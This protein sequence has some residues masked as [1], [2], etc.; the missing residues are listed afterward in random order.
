MAWVNSCPTFLIP[1]LLSPPIVA[2]T[3]IPH[4]PLLAVVSSSTIAIYECSSLLPLAL[5]K[6]DS[7]C[8]ATHKESVD[9]QI[10]HVSVDTSRLDQMHSVNVYVQTAGNYILIYHL[11]VNYSRSLYEVTDVQSDHLVQNSKPLAS[12]S[13]RFNFA[14]LIKSATKSLIQGG[15]ADTNLI[16]LEHFNNAALDDDQR[17]ENIPSVK[18]S[19]VKI[20]RMNAAITGFWC[21]LNS[22]N[23]IF[24]NDC[25][26]IQILNL[27]SFNN[28]IIKLLDAKWYHDT[29]LVAYN[30]NENYFLHLSSEGELAVLQFNQSSPTLSLDSTPLAKL[31]FTCRRILFNP[32]FNLVTLQTDTDLRIYKVTLGVK[33]ST[34]SYIKTLHEFQASDN[35]S[36]KWAPCGTFLI[37]W[38]LD[39]NYWKMISK[40]GFV[41]FDSQTLS[42]EIAAADIDAENLKA[43][44]DFCFVADCSIALNSQTLYLLNS[45]SSKIYYLDLLRL[46]ERF[47]NMSMFH[48]QTYVSV[49]VTETNSFARFPIL[50]TF[51]KVLEHFQYVNGIALDSSHRK[52]TGQLTIRASES[53]QLSMSYGP[54]LTVSTPIRIGTDFTHPLWYVFYNHFVEQL[55]IVDHFWVKDY[56]ILINRYARDDVDPDEMPDL[57]IDE[58]MIFNT[59]ASKHGAGGS[60]F[61]FDSD[62]LVWRHSFRNRIVT[63]E[64][65]DEED[66]MKTLVLITNDMRIILMELSKGEQTV[67]PG[68]AK[69]SIR[70]RRTIHL[71][72]IKH[73]LPITLIQQMTMVDGKH[74]FFLLNTGDMYLLKNQM[75]PENDVL[76]QRGTTQVNNM[77]DLIKISSAVESF[78][79]NSLNFN[80]ARHNRYITFFNGGE[81]LIYNIG[82]LVERIYEFEGIEHSGEVDAER[83]LRPIMIKVATFMP[84]KMYQS[85]GSIEVTGFEYQIMIKSDFLILKHRSSRQL[86]LNKFI[87]HDLFES[88]LAPT[89]ISR[90]YSNFGNYDYCL[91]LLLFE[92][93]YEIDERTRLYKVCQL[94][95]ATANSDSIYIN[96][97]RKIEVKYWEQFF[98][99]LNQT[100]KGFMNR[101]QE[102]NNVELCYNYLNIY[103]NFKREFESSATPMETEDNGSILDSKDRELITQIIKMLLEAQK[104]DECFE[105]CRYIK[106]LQPSGEILR[107]IRELF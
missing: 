26:E 64:L 49:P 34:L 62:L 80:H 103:L 65:I 87:Q 7:Q 98:K 53:L 38:N 69:L 22:Q 102:S 16:N 33:S 24:S 72:S 59:A 11:L 50:P 14:N 75:I 52:P 1:L 90:K 91:E 41:L 93:L 40:F 13:S 63:F 48:D 21:K 95:D 6:R 74:F 23:L 81:M 99:L 37:V 9:A 94:V 105:L 28:E 39:T 55:N 60:N 25:D 12:D 44:R 96:F 18:M 56:L 15:A 5:L 83:P 8:L 2:I 31:D 92:N 58:L 3:P 77:Y 68:S 27:K 88:N 67:K 73:K 4:T 54:H 10:R 79:V 42:D 43:L 20:L 19:L 97:L 17:N 78:Q 57:M 106:L 89:E 29:A 47:S 84:L 36:C 100:P 86:I 32:Q 45:D 101:L 71:S 66:G 30:L 76:N 82:E 61:K 104:W 85:N 35:I 51:Q 46:Q 107:E 70:V